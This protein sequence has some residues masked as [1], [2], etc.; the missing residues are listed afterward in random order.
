LIRGY[1]KGPG[2][3]LAVIRYDDPAAILALFCESAIEADKRLSLI[4]CAGGLNAFR[5]FDPPAH[6][7]YCAAYKAGPEA[8]RTAKLTCHLPALLAFQA[9]H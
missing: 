9:G 4:D 1:K 8:A 7:A 5:A 2:P 6:T 3:P